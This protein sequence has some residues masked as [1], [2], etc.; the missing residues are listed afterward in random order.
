[1]S[2]STNCMECGRPWGV[3]LELGEQPT[4]K[5]QFLAQ[6][7]LEEELMQYLEDGLSPGEVVN[8]TGVPQVEAEEIAWITDA[9]AA[10]A[11]ENLNCDMM[12]ESAC[13]CVVA[14]VD[15]LAWLLKGRKRRWAYKWDCCGLDLDK[16]IV[17]T[18]KAQTVAVQ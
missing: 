11:S 5:A 13:W 4:E 14:D 3:I 8:L 2:D 7:Q 12:P 10:F 1:M 15:L 18:V 17:K 9:L 16:F 6:T